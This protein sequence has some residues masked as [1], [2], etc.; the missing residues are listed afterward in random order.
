MVKWKQ[1][2]R[3]GDRGRDVSALKRLFRRAKIKGYRHLARN[4]K[5][6]AAFFVCLKEWQRFKKLKPDGVYGRATH[7][8]T[9]PM[10]T[11]YEAWLYRTSKKR[12]HSLQQPPLPRFWPISV[13]FMD[14]GGFRA[15]TL[16][17]IHPCL[18]P[19]V[20][21]ICKRFNLRVT[22]GYGGHPPHATHSDHRVGLAVDLAGS[23]SDMQ[24][25]NRWADGLRGKVFR[26]VGGPAHDSDGVEPGHGNH[27][28]L[29]WYRSHPTTIF[30]TSEFK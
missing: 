8:K 10:F 16:D 30:G 21:A 20:R 15:S 19:Q 18:V 29:S 13:W 2:I 9:A 3:S 6:G 4:D 26:W 7:A 14:N 25:C 22:D 27:V 1:P 17:G 12:K 5:A 28:H 23:L 11:P 24:R